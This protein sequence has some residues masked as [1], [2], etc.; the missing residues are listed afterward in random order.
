MATVQWFPGHMAKTKRLIKE[1]L[2]RVDLVI[3]DLDARAPL[4]SANPLLRKLTESKPRLVILNKDDLA[5]ATA[6]GRCCWKT[7]CIWIP[8]ELQFRSPTCNL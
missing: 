8:A 2:K 7:P 1:N 5:D 4:S 3:E 6:T